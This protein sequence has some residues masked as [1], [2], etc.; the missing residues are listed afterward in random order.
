M[1]ATQRILTVLTL[2]YPLAVYLGLQVMEPRWLGLLLVAILVLRH[3]QQ[4]KRFVAGM[5]AL[6]WVIFAAFGCFTLGIVAFNS[7]LL[8]LLYPAAVSLSLL[9]LFGRT[10]LQP[11]SMVE[12]FARLTEGDL[13]PVGVRYTRQVTQVWCVFFVF[14]AAIAIATVFASREYWV[15]YNGLVAYVLMGILFAG[16]WLVRSRQRNRTA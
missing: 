1:A 16:E 13:S 7:E 4:A 6:E 11:P 3:R 8:L 9:L 5:P 12:R 15:L 14:N 10:L 2:A